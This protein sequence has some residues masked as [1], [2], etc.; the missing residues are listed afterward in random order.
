MRSDD[1]E[2]KYH[3]EQHVKVEWLVSEIRQLALHIQI[4]QKPEV[5]LTNHQVCLG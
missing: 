1:T 5:H 4:L 2:V 3:R